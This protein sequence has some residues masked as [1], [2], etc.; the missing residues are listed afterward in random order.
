MLFCACRIVSGLLLLESLIIVVPVIVNGSVISVTRDVFLKDHK[1][2]VVSKT[3]DNVRRTKKVGRIRYH[4]EDNNNRTYSADTTDL[5]TSVFFASYSPLC[6]CSHVVVIGVGTSMAV[7]DYDILAQTIV[8]GTSVVVVVTNHNVNG[9]VKSSARQYA[10]LINAIYDQLE[11]LV[12]I[13]SIVSRNRASTF[14]KTKF[15]VGGHSSSGQAAFDASQNHLFDFRPVA[16]FGLDPYPIS[17]SNE[18]PLLQLPSLFWGFTKTTCFV[19]VR[20]AALGAYQLSSSDYGRVL[21]AI[22]NTHNHQITHCVFTDHGCGI[23]SFV[24]CPSNATAFGWVYDAV[25]ISL[26]V[27]LHVLDTKQLFERDMFELT[28]TKVGDVILFV[29]EDASVAQ[30]W[31][32]SIG[33]PLV[34]HT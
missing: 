6:P 9:I 29:N 23:G 28:E 10:Y 15:I 33:D 21:Y 7:K 4:Y 19:N 30:S 20:T 3:L 31:Q 16:F 17:F 5:G 25:A 14:T 18:E 27:Y 12:P 26:Q 8:R 13:C 34:P 22:D 2:A 24:V 32:L 11:E 1:D